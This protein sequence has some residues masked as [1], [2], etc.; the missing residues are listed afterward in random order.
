M[1]RR[2]KTSGGTNTFEPTYNPPEDTRVQTLRQDIRYALRQLRHAPTF[3]LTALLTLA[4]GIGHAAAENSKQPIPRPVT[5]GVATIEQ[6]VEG[7]KSL[8]DR[9]QEALDTLARL[10]ALHTRS[11]MT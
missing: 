7:E 10:R 1:A 8:E 4:V 2:K 3:T 5:P 9:Y 6:E 11:E